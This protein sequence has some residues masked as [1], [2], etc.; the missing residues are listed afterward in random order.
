MVS[1]EVFVGANAQVGFCPELDLFFPKGSIDS[2]KT[3]FTLSSGQQGDTLLVAGLYAGCMAKV[4]LNNSENETEYRMIVSNT[5]TAITL[6]AAVSSTGDNTHNLTIMA[7]GAP[8]YAKKTSG[9]SPLIQSD[10]WVGLVN[11]FTP[12]N[13][14]VEM[15][16]LNLA[17]AGGRNFDYQ[18][19]G[20]ETVSGGSLDLSLNNG[21][22]LYY[23]LGKITNLAVTAGASGSHSGASGSH[24]GVGFTVGTSSGRKLVRVIGQNMYPE[25]FDGSDGA[26]EDIV[27]PSSVPFNDNGATFSYTIE[28]ADNDVLPSFALDVVYRKAGSRA[29]SSVLDSLTPNE[30]MYSRIFTGCQVNS[31]AL[32][33]EEGQELK[34]S[35][36]LVTRRAFDAPNGYI[37]LGG[38]GS[39]LAAPSNSSGGTGM[40]NYSATLTDNYPFL[41]SDGSITL[42]GQSMARVKAGSLTI[43]NN[44]TPQRFIGNYNRETMSAHIPGQRTYELSLTM[45]I[46]D[47]KL[48]DEMRSANESSGALRLKFEKDSGEKIDLQFADYTINSVNVPFP[49]DKGAVEVEVTASARTLSSCNYT[50]KWAIYNIGGQATGN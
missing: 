49:E 11:T 21:S 4:D 34:S 17:V 15:K 3:V 22:W 23:T 40:H 8:A 26:D 36:E 19:K 33:F 10:N 43:A 27:L 16:Q 47:T 5:T 38:N 1:N 30:N 6:D 35:V 20:A 41:F 12:P 37:P 32:N 2:G 44:L 28:E 46:T 48:W 29:T 9:G 39:D 50:G 7:F 31:L 14:E 42:F 25:I 45:L 18:Y 13:V 24:N